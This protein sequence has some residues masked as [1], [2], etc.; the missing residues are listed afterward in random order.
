MLGESEPERGLP[1]HLRHTPDLLFVLASLKDRCGDYPSALDLLR[2]CLAQEVDSFEA[3]RAYLASAL[4]WSLADPVLAYYGQL[5]ADQRS[6]LTDALERLEP[7]EQ[8]LPAIQ[9]DYISLEVSNNVSVSLMLLGAKDRARV[10]ART[11]LPRHPLCE[12]L[13]RLRLN[14]LDELDDISQ[15]RA[16]TD[17]RLSELPLPILGILAEISAN[18]GICYGTLMLWQPRKRQAWRQKNRA[19]FKI[20]LFTQTG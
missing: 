6:A 5:T 11:S 12:G 20:P 13:L 9:S 16:L 14:E 18:R 4:E 10:L 7:L 8:T 19:S 2:K 1:E 15:I 17:A 3:K